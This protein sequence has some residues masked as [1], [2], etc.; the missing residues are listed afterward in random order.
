MMLKQNKKI[1]LIATGGTIASKTS[2]T[3][4]TPQMTPEEILV[5]VPE[6]NEICQVEVIQLFSLDST[7]ISPAHWL[8]MAGCVKAH[9]NQYDG[10]VITHGTDTLSYSAA[11]LSYLIQNN[12]KPVIL[13]G[14]QKSI[15]NKD[16]DARRNLIQSFQ[17]ATS[18]QACGVHVVFDGKVMIGTRTR[19]VRTKSYNAFSVID[20]PETAVFHDQ[21]LIF[22]LNEIMRN[23]PCKIYDT[24]NAKVFVLKLVPGISADIFTYLEQHYDG[25]VIESFGV[26]GLPIYEISE[27]A[28]ALESFI[29][30]NKTVVITT[31]VPHEGSDMDV[32]QVGFQMKQKLGLMEAYSMTIEAVVTKLM[33]ILGLT[34]DPQEIRRLFYTPIQKDLIE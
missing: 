1:L 7:N 26:G 11:A 18:N 17:F 20:Y 28:Q 24:L 14:S 5:L 25:V 23:E 4:L 30:K 33:W 6:I 29:G 9:Y 22:Y 2:E 10:F 27:F 13:T 34:K 31:Q 21:K 12:R 32:Y 16:T 8:A 15:F 3:G 19:K